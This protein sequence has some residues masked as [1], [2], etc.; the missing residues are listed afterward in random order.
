M[1][2]QAERKWKTD[3]IFGDTII[4]IPPKLKE[5]NPF[6]RKDKGCSLNMQKEELLLL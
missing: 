6:L 1:T 3:S 4:N 2:E 5:E